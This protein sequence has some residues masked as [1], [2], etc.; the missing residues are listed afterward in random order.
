MNIMKNDGIRFK[1]I[2]LRN[3]TFQVDVL[4][5]SPLGGSIEIGYM[6][7]SE[8]TF[9]P[10]YLMVTEVEIDSDYQKIG[11]VSRRIGLRTYEY[12]LK[13]AQ[14]LG[15]KGL[16][17][18]ESNQNTL[19]HSLWVKYKTHQIDEFYFMEK[20]IVENKLS[21]KSF[22]NESRYDKHTR[23]KNILFNDIDFSE[24]SDALKYLVE[25]PPKLFRGSYEYSTQISETKPSQ[26]T[27]RSA[28]TANYYTVYI[29]SAIEW[30]D[31]PSRAKSIIC[32]NSA[33]GADTYGFTRVVIPKNSAV[34]GV[35]PKFDFWF[36]FSETFG[37]FTNSDSSIPTI[38]SFT[39]HLYAFI[40][41]MVG[42]AEAG[43]SD[44]SYSA[45]VKTF[46]LVDAAIDRMM[47]DLGTNDYKI[48]FDT[49]ADNT[50]ER[51]A[52]CSLY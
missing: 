15:Y 49:Y 8:N 4:Q 12:A 24:Y 25:N 37:L 33:K 48:F 41:F 1:I 52:S 40:D 17:S 34:F 45:M 26:H 23:S 38:D 9:Y 29:D 14:R 27:R 42:S 51:N 3:K 30:Q 13:E 32:S 20:L 50:T 35:C 21:F 39:D 2:E 18:R 22:L 43:V 46:S 5:D 7:L 47:Y 31:Y 6:L 28:N 19:S 36:S 10:E 44:K 11:M 16:M